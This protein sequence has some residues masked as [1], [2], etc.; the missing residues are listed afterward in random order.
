MASTTADEALPA[1]PAAQLTALFARLP[2]MN[3][4]DAIDKA[5]VEFAYLNSKASRKRL[6]KVR[7]SDY[8]RRRCCGDAVGTVPGRRQPIQTGPHPL[9]CPNGGDARKVHA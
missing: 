1:A 9:L 6:V 2:D 7:G 5:A 3:A 4:R 8:S